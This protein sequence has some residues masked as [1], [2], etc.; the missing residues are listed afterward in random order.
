[1]AQ[2]GMLKILIKNI[3]KQPGPVGAGLV[4][5]CAVRCWCPLMAGPVGAGWYRCRCRYWYS[6]MPTGAYSGDGPLE[7]L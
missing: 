6:P 4:P 7:T 3:I 2:K 5:V 1:M